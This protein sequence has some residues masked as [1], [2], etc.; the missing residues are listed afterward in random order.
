MSAPDAPREGAATETGPET[1]TV[2]VTVT[3]TGTYGE[4]GWIRA[5]L[6]GLAILLLGF[7]GGVGGANLILTKALGLTRDAR[8]WIAT[9]LFLV[10]VIALAWVMRR[11][12]A[13]GL[14]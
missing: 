6:S 1:K 13:R 9:G 7:V 14:I 8:Q 10:V 11:L 12:Q 4:I 5:T 2:S 3:V